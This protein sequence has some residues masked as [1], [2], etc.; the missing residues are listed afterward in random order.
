[1]KTKTILIF[2]DIYSFFMSLI[3]DKRE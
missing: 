2:L 1:M 3:E